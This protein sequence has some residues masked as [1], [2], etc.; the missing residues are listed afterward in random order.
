[1]L[2][3][4]KEVVRAKTVAEAVRLLRRGKGA[5]VPLAGGTS[6]ALSSS[7][8]VVGLV[9]L[10][11]VHL[12]YVRETARQVKIGA[13]TRIQEIYRSA[14][15]RQ[16][17]G[18]MLCEAAHAVASTPNRNLITLGGNIV[19]L[20][21]W[22]VMPVALLAL[23]AEI[24]IVGRKR[25]RVV[26]VEFFAR[27][28]RRFL[29]HDEIVTEITVAKELGK[30]AAGAFIK[31]SRTATDY[32]LLSVAAYVALEG[33]GVVREARIAVGSLERLPRRLGGAEKVLIGRGADESAFRDAGERAAAL[34]A[35]LQDMRASSEYKKDMLAVCVR[36]ALISAAGKILK[37]KQ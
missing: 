15:L 3:A 8:E 19:A 27:H 9:D 12:D 7:K 37:P 1:M 2:P 32:P 13:M 17:A 6:L 24:G 4:L 34:V 22:S 23:E 21:M 10:S 36:R 20:Y 31:F 35:P 26:A 30:R 16:I 18:G 29:A 11:R 25:R 14:M 28:P 33:D 5:Y